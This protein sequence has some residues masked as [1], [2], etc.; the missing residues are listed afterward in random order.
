MMRISH[1]MILNATIYPWLNPIQKSPMSSD[2]AHPLQDLV[3]A[4]T[5]LSGMAQESH[6][7]LVPTIAQSSSKSNPLERLTH[8]AHRKKIERFPFLH[9]P[10]PGD[11]A[12][13]REEH[14]ETEWL[15]LFYG[16]SNPLYSTVF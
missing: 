8:G 4:H 2:T 15:D 16:E 3:S 6:V 1:S 10:I 13:L 12:W 5:D 11:E 9:P 14:A 7:L